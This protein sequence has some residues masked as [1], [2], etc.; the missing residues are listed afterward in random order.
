[1]QPFSREKSIELNK[2]SVFVETKMTLPS[3]PPV[4]LRHFVLTQV[5][6]TTLEKI[7]S[8]HHSIA[9]CID[10]VMIPRGRAYRGKRL[11]LSVAILDQVAALISRRS[12]DDGVFCFICVPKTRDWTIMRGV[13]AQSPRSLPPPSLPPPPLFLPLLKLDDGVLKLGY[14]NVKIYYFDDAPEM[15]MLHSL[16]YFFL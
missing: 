7:C 8:T 5:S 6:K 2:I 3:Q 11:F 16:H 1:L 14:E 12:F 9:I 15:F 4:R 10:Q 13:A